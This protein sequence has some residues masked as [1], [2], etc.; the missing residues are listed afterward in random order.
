M[1]S[2]E[3]KMIR[4]VVSLLL[5]FLIT[6]NIQANDWKISGDVQYRMRFNY[7][8]NQ[9]ALEG[10][11]DPTGDYSN[12]Y[13]WNVRI[14]KK[15]TENLKFGIRLSNPQG[16][17]TDGVDQNVEFNNGPGLSIPEFYFNYSENKWS[18]SA[19]IIPVYSNVV[20]NVVAAE[21]FRGYQTGGLCDVGI[22]PW[23]VG[24]NNSQIGMKGSYTFL[25][26]G[27]MALSL[28]AV[29]STAGNNINNNVKYAN[30]LKNDNLRFILSSP[31]TLK[32][33]NISLTP[34]MHIKSGWNPSLKETNF[35]HTAGLDAGYSALD[36]INP[37]LGIA[38]GNYGKYTGAT[39]TADYNAYYIRAKAGIKPGFGKIR[40]SL[41]Y[42]M[43]TNDKVSKSRNNSLTYLDVRYV[44]PVKDFS[45]APRLRIWNR[46]NDQNEFGQMYIRPEIL[47]SAKF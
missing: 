38:Y 45:I 31:I 11:N 2:L 34:I 21:E 28:K 6:V 3:K 36:W 29:T 35:S 33:Q 19:G 26:D 39:K 23:A 1:D 43:S 44:I 20:L 46:Y 14:K 27:D 40:S 24:K 22:F 30:A 37:T 4:I 12:R 16:Y 25:N 32:N 18:F 41:S 47:F 5:V 15:V 42:G 17:F 13:W 7:I 9:G 10:D 8:D